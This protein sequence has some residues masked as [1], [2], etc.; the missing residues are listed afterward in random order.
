MSTRQPDPAHA[1]ALI[2]NARMILVGSDLLLYFLNHDG[3]FS[4]LQ[5]ELFPIDD[6]SLELA[7]HDGTMYSIKT[8]GPLVRQ[9]RDN[10]SFNLEYLGIVMQAL[11]MNIGDELA[12]NQYFTKTPE[13]EF[14]RHIRNALGHGNRFHFKGN[15]PFRQATL[16]GRTLSRDLNGQKVFFQYMM[17]GDV[18]DL[19]D[20]L[21]S[22]LVA[23]H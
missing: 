13:L 8:Y 2:R 11:L 17:G 9:L 6:H 7:R 12:P 14:S 16:R 21:E 23:Y 18:F 4:E 10:P 15:E 19:L 20:D 1:L 5:R 22:Q 3:H